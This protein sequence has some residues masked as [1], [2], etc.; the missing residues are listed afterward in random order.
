MHTS[1]FRIAVCLAMFIAMPVVAHAAAI[2]I[3][4]GSG[5]TYTASGKTWIADAHFSGGSVVNRGSVAIT[6][7]TDDRLYQT[8]RYGLSGY[9]IPVANDTYVVKLYFAE[10]YEGTVRSGQRVFDVNV[11]GYD[12]NNLDVFAVAGGRNKAIVRTLY[13]VT[14]S[15]GTLNIVFTKKSGAPMIS[16]I[17]ILSEVT[18]PVDGQCGSAHLTPTASKPTTNLCS[19]GIASA[20]TGTGPWSWTCTGMNGGRNESCNA[21]KRSV[22]SDGRGRVRVSGGTVV[23]DRGTLLHGASMMIL[24]NPNY[25]TSPAHWKMLHDLGIN[26]VRLDVKTAQIGKTTLQQLPELDKAVNLAAANKMYIMIKS[27]MKPGGYNL[28]SLREFWTIAAPRYK[29]R[30]HV[31]YEVTNEPVSGG[32]RWGDADQW[33]DKVL[34]D[35]GGIYAIMRKGAPNTHITIFSTPNLSDSPNA[36]PKSCNTWKALAAKAK[37][38]VDWSKT[39]ISFHHYIGTEEFGEANLKCLKASYPLLMTET[40]YWNDDAA[41][42]NNDKT[43]HRLYEKLGIS[44]F[45]LDGKGSANYLKNDIIPD[46]RA[47]GYKINVEN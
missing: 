9:N 23:T 22:T 36:Y 7:T 46:L 25:S 44:W 11:E 31:I 39:S 4:S 18:S 1:F 13:N 17:E 2:R 8:E 47:Q 16:A 45:S 26:A 10:T 43:V 28:A 21:P 29:D 6:N 41:A 12:I 27:S 35:L 14:V 37:G 38:G 5:T 40:N 34:T 33:T 20:V 42:Q 15:D 19:A 24:T 32:P 30:T 3:E